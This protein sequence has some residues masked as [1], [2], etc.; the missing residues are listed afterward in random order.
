VK[1]HVAESEYKKLASVKTRVVESETSRR[2][3]SPELLR[4]VIPV[5]V[6]ILFTLLVSSCD[7]GESAGEKPVVVVTILPQAEFVKKVGGD[8]VVVTVMV[9]PGANVHIYEPTPFQM[10]TLAEASMYAKVGSGIEFELTWMEKLQAVNEEMLVVDCSAGVP[11]QEVTGEV[12]SLEIDPH[13]WMSPGNVAI[14]V[15]NI[16]DGLVTIDAA[17]KAYYARNRDAYLWELDRLDQEI[18]DSLSGVPDRTFMVYHPS[19]GYFA[20]EYDLTML[21]IENEG[22]EPTAAGMARMITRAKESDITVIFA[23]PQFNPQSARVIADAIGGK[24]V[25]VDS[26]AGDYLAN[27]GYFLGDLV[28]AMDRAER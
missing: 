6:I 17:N 4:R 22:K 9:P 18:R 14:M 15:Q 24:V 23:D 16:Y 27:T 1:I 13:I 25:F 20:R 12:E 8:R 7:R 2:S 3:F 19:L 5:L 11:L 28:S 26:L 10:T 21:S